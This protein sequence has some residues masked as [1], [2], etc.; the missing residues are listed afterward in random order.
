MEISRLEFT[1]PKTCKKYRTFSKDLVHTTVLLIFFYYQNLSAL[2]TKVLF[3]K[4]LLVTKTYKLHKFLHFRKTCSSL[5]FQVTTV[6][7]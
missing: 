7:V 3:D 1:I 4:E 2:L 6:T 5:N